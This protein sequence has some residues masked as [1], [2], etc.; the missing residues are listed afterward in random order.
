MDDAMRWKLLAG[1]GGA[2][3]PFHELSSRQQSKI[4]AELRY[5]RS[6]V[7]S[8]IE[9]QMEINVQQDNDAM[10]YSPLSD[11]TDG[12]AALLSEQVDHVVL[13][14]EGDFCQRIEE[15]SESDSSTSDEFSDVVEEKPMFRDELAKCFAGQRI[16]HVQ[17]N[18]ILKVLRSHKCHSNLPKDTRTLL[19]TPRNRIQTVPMGSGEY[20]HIGFESGILRALSGLHN[21]S[22][23]AVLEIDISIDGGTLDRSGTIHIWPIQFRIVNVA[24]SKPQ[25][26]GVYKGQGKPPCAIEF[27]DAFI[28]EV[29]QLRATHGIEFRGKR[30]PF[31]FRCFIADAPARAFILNHRGHNASR[32]CSKCKVSGKYYKS[33][34]IF[35]GTNHPLRSDEEYARRVDEDHHKEGPS[36]FS[37]LGIRM[38]SRVPFEYMHLGCIGAMKKCIG[39]W[40]MGDY[41]EDTKLPD[42]SIYLISRRLEALREYCPREFARR[43]T[44]LR[45]YKRWKATEFRQFLLYT[46]PVVLREI[47]PDNVHTYFLLLHAIF[48]ILVS[49]SPSQNQLFFADIAMKKWVERCATLYGP[50]FLSYNIHGLSHL[51]DDVR[52]LGPLDKFFSVPIREQYAIF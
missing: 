3:K 40:V 49:P 4:K 42:W 24:H 46:G 41:T 2:R 47:L 8:N 11:A 6:S 30:I 34:M 15:S 33:R 1:R 45:H 12:A 51:V 35:L 22:I 26:L 5:L 9:S 50:E 38:P 10:R 19:Q 36:P 16:T 14:D 27:F 18:A 20:L 25:I 7:E 23:P 37:E 28:Q 48:R 32:A 31:N 52:V 21:E 39:A 17:G 43:P 13:E 29:K 44:T